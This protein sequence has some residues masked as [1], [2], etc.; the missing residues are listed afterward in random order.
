MHNALFLLQARQQEDKM[1]AFAS[2]HG[3]VVAANI[4]KVMMMITL[5]MIKIIITS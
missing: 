1:A 5:I 2:K 4:L 3:E